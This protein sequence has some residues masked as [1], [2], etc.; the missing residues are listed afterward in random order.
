MMMSAPKKAQHNIQ[1]AATTGV[2]TCSP[3]GIQSLKHD[4]LKIDASCSSCMPQQCVYKL[5]S[6][7]PNPQIQIIISWILSAYV[8]ATHRNWA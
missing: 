3:Q 7:K 5:A 4:S 1:K 6:N 8:V 2:F